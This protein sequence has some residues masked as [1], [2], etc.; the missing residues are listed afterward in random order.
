[1]AICKCGNELN[2]SSS[3]CDSCGAIQRKRR[4]NSTR[5]ILAGVIFILGILTGIALDRAFF[6][7]KQKTEKIQANKQDK[8]SLEN[9]EKKK[10]SDMM[11]LFSA[12]NKDRQ[13]EKPKEKPE[14]AQQPLEPQQAQQTHEEAEPMSE[15]EPSTEP[16]SELTTAPTPA[17]TLPEPSPEPSP[18]PMLTLKPETSPEPEPEPASEPEPETL[19]KLKTQAEPEPLASTKPDLNSLNQRLVLKKELAIETKNRN[20]YHGIPTQT[21]YMFV[22]DREKINGRFTYQCYVKTIPNTQAIKL[23]SW[24]GN[25][26]TPEPIP[27]ENKILFSSDKDEPEQIY[28]IDLKTSDAKALTSGK[29]K[30]MMPAISPKGDKIAFVSN[31]NG[32]NA[33]CIMNLDGT[34]QKSLTNGAYD[35]REPRWAQQGDA[36]IFTR[37]FQGLKKSHILK[38]DLATNKI[39]S[40]V[41]TNDRNWLADLSPDGRFLLFTKSESKTGSMNAIFL[42]DLHLNTETR[43]ALQ[44]AENLRPIWAQDSLSFLFHKISKAGRT[45]HRVE[46]QWEKL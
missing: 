36:I 20:N 42:K 24:E 27:G 46:L 32:R 11:V 23:F 12:D 25:V 13:E 18:A 41:D 16:I 35:D 31:R 34:N 21:G 43:L 38:I 9:P 15:P 7:A 19:S 14:H 22:S 39:E 28:V 29:S 4:V 30:N 45:L 40:L 2:N 10:A 5:M 3:V 33:I 44:G 17:F 26:W 37:I 8:T 1:M 6:V